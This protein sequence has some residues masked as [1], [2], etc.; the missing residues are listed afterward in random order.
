MATTGTHCVSTACFLAALSTLVSTADAHAQ[1]PLSTWT[2]IQ[3]T[4]G[5][6]A[7]LGRSAAGSGEEPGRNA[8]YEFSAR[9]DTPVG[10]HHLVRIEVGR[11]A[12]RFENTNYVQV[13]TACCPG[14][15]TSLPRGTISDRV[16]ITRVTG[17]VIRHLE[18]PHGGWTP[19]YAGGGIGAYH[20]EPAT[21]TSY[22]RPWRFGIHGFAGLEVPIPGK[23]IAIG[24]EV[25]LH[26]PGVP[27]NSAVPGNWLGIVS[28]SLGLK[29]R[30]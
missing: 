18:H 26:M 23:H 16:A 17:S 10:D 21:R 15:M 5:I 8:T 9:V 11:A 19:F 7:V 20:F 6:T 13:P 1:A 2:P 29:F 3:Q 22:A 4:P 27:P 12:W 28:A 30:M 24:A 14:V 25:Q